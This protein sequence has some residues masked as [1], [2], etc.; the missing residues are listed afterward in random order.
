MKVINIGNSPLQAGEVA[1]GCMRMADMS[2]KD[3]EN[4]IRTSLEEGVT[5][6]DHAD[7]Y[8]KG[9]SEEVFGKAIDLKGADRDKMILQSK[10][11]IRSGFYDFSKEHIVTSVDSILK[12]LGADHL[13]IL[14]LHRPDALMEPEEVASA[15]SELKKSGKVNYFGV[16]NH[17]P[18]QIELL[19]QY[20]D[21]SLIVNQVQLSL[22]HTPIIDAGLQ[23]NMHQDG[24]IH[25][26]GMLLEYCRKENITIQAWS[27][28]QHGMIEGPFIDND[29]FPE[30]NKKLR[31]LAE[32]KGI[33]KTTAA[34]A[35]LLRIPA[36]IQ[37]VVG[38]MTPERIRQAAAASKVDLTREEWYGLYTAA[39]NDLP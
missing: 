33:S 25:R 9:A 3:A 23:V 27:P 29:D 2:P 7:I 37:P 5:L 21:V 10:C 18:G 34:A 38:S 17:H 1:L 8:G 16:S 28:F 36:S 35:W 4:V 30:L 24:A 31:E 22:M 19:K 6:F 11:G 32:E 14:V 15:F 12:R 26:D 13:D 20:V 39:G